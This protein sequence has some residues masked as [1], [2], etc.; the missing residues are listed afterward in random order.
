M[1]RTILKILIA[2]QAWVVLSFSLMAKDASFYAANS[3][4]SS[5]SWYKI[6]I[7][8]DG[9]YKLTYEDLVG[10]GIANPA[11]AQIWGY[12]GWMLDEDFSANYYDDLPQVAVWVNKERPG[13]CANK[14]SLFQL[15]VLL[16]D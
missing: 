2:I 1:N 6:R 7:S 16:C 11:H 4:L 9:V 15:W 3:V 13:L 10:M 12:G 8:S 14:Q 5:G